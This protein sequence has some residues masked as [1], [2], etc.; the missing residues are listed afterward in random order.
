MN[1]SKSILDWVNQY[2]A[3]RQ[4]LGFRMETEQR[5]L[6]RFA[7]Y[8]AKSFQT[9]PLTRE[10]FLDWIQTIPSASRPYQARRLAT[11]RSFAKYMAIYEPATEIPPARLFGKTA[12]RS[13]PHIY[14]K[15]ELLQL[16]G[17][18]EQL[19]SAGGLRAKT[20]RLL[21]GLLAVTGMRVSEAL[22]L[23][24]NDVDLENGVITVRDTKFRKSRLLPLHLSTTK[25]LRQYV[26]ARERYLPLGRSE[27]FLLSE[28]GTR[29]PC[30]TVQGFFRTARQKLG[31]DNRSRK[32]L[33]R[34]HDMR[35]SFACC[36]ILRWYQA[37]LDVEQLIPAL[38]TYLGHAKVSDTYWY[39]TGIPAIFRL[40]AKRFERYA[41]KESNHDE[42][43]Q[44]A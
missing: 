39:L 7:A 44:K 32:R 35:H 5:E 25:V 37:G 29:L 2:V 31:W 16:F 27:A 41:G 36:R 15:Q 6:V 23:N 21:F 28:K 22:K 34:I 13:E 4:E 1:P 40:A 38:S 30:R 11:L 14:T 8:A 26:R 42:N 18:C 33:P 19:K 43:C 20:Y 12:S 9:G 24:D 3:R 10:L 17:F